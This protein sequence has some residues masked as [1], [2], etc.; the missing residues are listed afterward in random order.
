MRIS[1]LIR[2]SRPVQVS[3]QAIDIGAVEY[4][5]DHRKHPRPFTELPEACLMGL[6]VHLWTAPGP[7][8]SRVYVYLARPELPLDLS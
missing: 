7:E 5:P 4:L 2:P 3:E 1:V 6:M 8:I